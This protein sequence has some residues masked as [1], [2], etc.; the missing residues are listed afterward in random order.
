MNETITARVRSVTWENAKI[1]TYELRP[2]DI[3]AFP[4]FTA[5]AHIDLSCRTDW[6][7]AIR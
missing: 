3:A 6:C 4:A 7:A 5:G 2:H 1:R